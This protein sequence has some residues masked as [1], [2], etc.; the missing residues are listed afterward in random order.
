MKPTTLRVTSGVLLRWIRDHSGDDFQPSMVVI[1]NDWTKK[2]V[3]AQLDTLCR[4]SPFWDAP[5]PPPS[6]ALI[7][8]TPGLSFIHCY[9]ISSPL[10]M[11]GSIRR[12]GLTACGQYYLEALENPDAASGP[13]LRMALKHP[14]IESA[15]AL[16]IFEAVPAW[17]KAL[18][19]LSVVRVMLQNEWGRTT[20]AWSWRNFIWGTLLK[21]ILLGGGIGGL[22]GL[23]WLLVR[24]MA[25]K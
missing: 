4:C 7:Q 22:V 9:P 13:Y 10:P 11:D 20:Q 24:A 15:E 17:K 8:R 19:H 23:I 16:A 5:E 25:S 21:L 6:Q 3:W 1:A 18:A 2:I 14:E 12:Y